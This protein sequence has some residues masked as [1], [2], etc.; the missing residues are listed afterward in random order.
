MDLKLAGQTV[1]VTGASQGIG[2]AIAEAFAAEGS[3]VVINAR[4]ADV[5]Q[6]LSDRLQAT[7]GV[8]VTP[9]AADIATAQGCETVL[10]GLKDQPL[11]GLVLN[12]GGPPAGPFLQQSPGVWEQ[13]AQNLLI[14]G[15]R[16]I[17][18]LH[19]QLTGAVTWLT[20]L[21]AKEPNANLVLSNTYRAGLLGLV[22]TLS[23]ELAP[24]RV[25]GVLPGYTATERLFELADAR[26][27]LTGAD[28]QAVFDSFAQSVP[29]KRLADPAEI[30]RVVVFLTSP[31]ASYVTGANL[32][33]DGGRYGGIL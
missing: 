13:Q 20:S 14:S 7:Y 9:V 1:L 21:A 8:R 3:H 12:T 33:V 18:G 11:A 6:T 30:A 4:R 16:L 22:K 2:A 19:P 15:V 26:A 29:L 17:Q 5:L 32:Q 23:Q 27:K 24:L 28:A 10:A 31:A 25:N